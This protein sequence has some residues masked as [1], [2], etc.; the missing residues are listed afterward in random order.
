M[1]TIIG[2]DRKVKVVITMLEKY[3]FAGKSRRYND[4]F[5]SPA[6]GLRIV[7]PY[8]R[9]EIRNLLAD[10][11]GYKQILYLEKPDNS[12]SLFFIVF[13]LNGKPYRLK[14]RNLREVEGELERLPD[15]V[16]RENNIYGHNGCY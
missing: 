16:L 14:T 3:Y 5:Y 2:G 8:A 6:S 15:S 12:N 1:L 10:Y 7:F 9:H 4:M 11:E 13:T